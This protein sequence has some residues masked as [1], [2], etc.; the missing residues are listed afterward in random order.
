MDSAQIVC[1]LVKKNVYHP[2]LFIYNKVTMEMAE[3]L[4]GSHE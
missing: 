1:D 2:I 3:Q 4:V